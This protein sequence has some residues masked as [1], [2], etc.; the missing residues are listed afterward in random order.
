MALSA[1]PKLHRNG[2]VGVQFIA[3]ASA[4]FHSA[5]SAATMRATDR[6][7][8]GGVFRDDAIPL[9][10]NAR[11]EPLSAATGVAGTRHRPGPMSSASTVGSRPP[12]ACGRRVW[13]LHS[14]QMPTNV[15]SAGIVVHC[16]KTTWWLSAARRRPVH[17]RYGRPGVLQHTGIHPA[18]A[19]KCSEKATFALDAA[20]AVMP[21]ARGTRARLALR[22][23]R[24]AGPGSRRSPA[25]VPAL[26]KSIDA[27]PSPTR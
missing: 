17:S 25:H 2:R 15:M 20:A 1:W 24:Q 10:Q 18:A 22:P 7:G 3:L 4:F 26:Q 12:R 19:R 16:V 8:E 14:W 21:P 11:R 6:A 23:T 5:E 13:D 27:G 9:L